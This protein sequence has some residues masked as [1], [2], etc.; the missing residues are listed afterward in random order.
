[1]KHTL[2]NII[3]T[4]SMAE[5]VAFYER[6][7]LFRR[8]DGEVNDWWNE[9]AVGDTTL[10]LHWN[11]DET[12]PAT[13]NPELNFR[14]TTEEFDALYASIADLNPS[15]IDT[16]RGLGRFFTVMDPNGIRV[17]MNEA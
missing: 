14:L 1:M 8:E 4:N 10:A 2:L 9:F 16:L 3:Y 15:G 13:G 7:G 17:Q 12:L 6:L 5:S 11:R